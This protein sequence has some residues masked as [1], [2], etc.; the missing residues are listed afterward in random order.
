[1]KVADLIV[2]G[3]L[4]LFS[5]YL[6]IKSTEL[7]IGWIAGSGPGGGAFPFWLSLGM[8][9]CCILI[10]IRNLLRLSPEGRSTEIF[11]DQD[12]RHLFWVVFI[13]L[14]IF[15]GLIHIIGVY[16]SVPLFMMFYMRYLGKHSWRM[17]VIV[18]LT[19]PVV[20]FLFFEK[21][22]IILLPK[23]FTEPLF[24]IFY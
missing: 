11:M 17:V 2:A 15:I 10:I 8:L 6:M 16:F 23:G 12:I 5:I 9:I 22:L 1:M 18:S 24:Y 14:T 19:V 4:A 7:P 13:S 3:V 21:M 20:T